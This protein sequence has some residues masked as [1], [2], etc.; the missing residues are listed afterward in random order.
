[1]VVDNESISSMA[2]SVD[3]VWNQT[4]TQES[5]NILTMFLTHLLACPCGS[6]KRAQR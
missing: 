1:M 5:L 3:Y 6:M 2:P 4:S